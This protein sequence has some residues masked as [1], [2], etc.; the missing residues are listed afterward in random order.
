M[1]SGTLVDIFFWF[2]W[3]FCFAGCFC[4][5]FCFVFKFVFVVVLMC[6][7][8]Q[9]LEM[10][11]SFFDGHVES[12]LF[13]TVHLTLVLLVTNAIEIGSLVSL[14]PKLLRVI[15]QYCPRNNWIKWNHYDG[16]FHYSRS[17]S[18][19][20]FFASQDLFWNPRLRQSLCFLQQGNLL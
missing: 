3:W 14:F 2:K 19:R 15:F 9:L 1:W 4:F 7:N 16:R 20:F 5:L 8:K 18:L 11:R 17:I 10:F 13:T 12:N 6:A